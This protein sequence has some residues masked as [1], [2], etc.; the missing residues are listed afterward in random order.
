MSCMW[1]VVYVVHDDGQ[2][3]QQASFALGK[4]GGWGAPHEAAPPPI[5]VDEGQT[6]SSTL[7]CLTLGLTLDNPVPLDRPA[8][9]SSK[10][11]NPLFPHPRWTWKGGASL[12]NSGTHGTPLDRPARLGSCPPFGGL[13]RI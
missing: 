7:L 1:Y 9:E 5:R 4:Q 6:V 12:Q 2:R 11:C 8:L 13:S 3:C 10:C